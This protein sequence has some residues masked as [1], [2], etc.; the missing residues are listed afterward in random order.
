MV[1][2]LTSGITVKTDCSNIAT[3]PT[4]SFFLDGIEYQLTGADY[5]LKVTALGESECVMGI[6]S[7]DMPSGFNYIIL[8]D[9]FM[10]KYYTYFDKNNNTVGFAPAA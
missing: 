5:V 10:R 6:M 7:M 3:L 4:I 2:K 1:G 9:V 8:G